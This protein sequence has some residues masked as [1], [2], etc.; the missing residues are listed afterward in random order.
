VALGT[1]RARRGDA[2]ARG[3]LAEAWELS[4]GTQSETR[5]P[6]LSG[7]LEGAW[8]GV[9]PS[10]A[11][12][13]VVDLLREGERT[14]QHLRLA[15]AAWWAQRHGI[16][17]ELQPRCPSPWWLMH[18]GC[19]IEAIEAW[20]ALDAPYEEALAR[21]YTRDDGQIQQGLAMLDRL[22]AAASRAAVGRELGVDDDRPA[23][24]GPRATTR[25]NPFGLTGRE[26]EVARL[27]ADGLTNNEIADRLVVSA[28]TVDHHVSAV[29]AKVGI[30]NRASVGPA[31]ANRKMG[32]A[33][34]QHGE[35][36]R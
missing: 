21:C 26:L 36:S 22:G 23:A 12:G 34:A 15:E 35:S 27:V 4:E 8:L 19:F 28:K 16:R 30:S 11:P 14:Q 24:R 3:A 7:L 5:L 25:S 29:L 20:R 33:K 6:A 10:P 2:G 13:V 32:N 9:L 1:I 17:L 31:L 18:D